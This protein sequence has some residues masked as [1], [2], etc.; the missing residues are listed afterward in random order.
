[1]ARAGADLVL[2]AERV[3]AQHGLSSAEAASRA[4]RF[5]PNKFAEDAAEPRW[6]AF[7]RQYARICVG[8]SIIVVHGSVTTFR[9]GANSMGKPFRS[10]RGN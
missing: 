8:L 1:M 10:E 2:Q 7:I 5:G 9:D 4:E 3:D 6:R